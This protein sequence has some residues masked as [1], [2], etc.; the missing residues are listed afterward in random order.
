MGK[1]KSI[2]AN[3]QP[4]RPRSSFIENQLR[5]VAYC[6][7]STDSDKQKSNY[8]SQVLHYK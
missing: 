6:R 4:H 8:Q 7:A 3:K 5:V 1:V 2:E